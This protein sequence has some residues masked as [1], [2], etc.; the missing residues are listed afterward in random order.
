MFLNHGV[1]SNIVFGGILACFLSAN[2]IIV[3]KTLKCLNDEIDI[4][5]AALLLHHG[6][7]FCHSGRK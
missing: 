3:K 6:V 2:I 5:H 7:T 1:E 4:G